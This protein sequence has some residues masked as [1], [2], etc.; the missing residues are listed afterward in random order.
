MRNNEGATFLGGR[1]YFRFNV[2]FLRMKGSERA[3]G[4]LF[5]CSISI[6]TSILLLSYDPKW[7]QPMKLKYSFISSV[8]LLMNLF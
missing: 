1:G 2:F 4:K 3:L 5:S 7:S 8:S 6:T